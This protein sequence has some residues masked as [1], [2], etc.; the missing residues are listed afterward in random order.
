[1][2]PLTDDPAR[3]LKL[4]RVF[5]ECR[6][7]KVAEFTVARAKVN[8]EGV[9]VQFSE[10]ASRDEAER[11]TGAYILIGREELLPLEEDRFYHFEVLGFTVRTTSGKVLGKVADVLD[12]PANAVFVVRNDGQEVLI[13]AIKDVVKKIDTAVREIVIDPIEGLLD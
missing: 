1:M 5:V 7:G 8:N 4:K 12:M 9:L 10:V 2:R 13:P 11:L 3:F 6:D